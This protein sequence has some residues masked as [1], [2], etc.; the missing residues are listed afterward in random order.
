MPSHSSI[1]RWRCLDQV[2]P[3]GE[4]QAEEPV[5]PRKEVVGLESSGQH[6]QRLHVV[7]GSDVI[8]GH[9]AQ[10]GQHLVAA[11]H[12]PLVAAGRAQLDASVEKGSCLVW[13]R[14]GGREAEG[15]E[16]SG[17]RPV[18]VYQFG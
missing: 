1:A 8:A 14:H 13:C 9:P 6:T 11:E 7:G 2:A 3:T 12:R 15:V 5:V 4:E 16:R 18:V 10:D 17:T